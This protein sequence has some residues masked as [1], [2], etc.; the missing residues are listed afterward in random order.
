VSESEFVTDVWTKESLNGTSDDLTY[1][2][3]SDSTSG[4]DLEVK[5]STSPVVNYSIQKSPSFDVSHSSE[6]SFDGGDPSAQKQKTREQIPWLLAIIVAF[7]VDCILFARLLYVEI[8]GA[9]WL[10]PWR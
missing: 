7:A 3:G 8:R 9:E 1:E 4:S 5:V 6:P 10:P 2:K